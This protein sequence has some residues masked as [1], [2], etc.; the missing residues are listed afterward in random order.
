M[1]EGPSSGTSH[2][3]ARS[4]PR[5]RRHAPGGELG[6]VRALDELGG[7]LGDGREHGRRCG[8]EHVAPGAVLE[9]GAELGA[10]ATNAPA[11][12]A[13]FPRVPTSASTGT[14]R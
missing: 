1:G 14:P 11:I 12:P 4:A 3:C 7:G 10:P 6:S 9:E 5:T 13:A 2:P 8:R